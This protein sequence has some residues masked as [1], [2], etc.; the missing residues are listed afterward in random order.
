MT[1]ILTIVDEEN[2]EVGTAPL[3]EVYDKRLN[4][5]IV[6][7]LVFNS[8]G[9]L[10]LQRLSA[11]KKFCPG[12]WGTSAAGHVQQKESYEEAA[13][14]ELKEELC[15]KTPATMIHSCVYPHR[16]MKKFIQV[17]R[18][19]HDGP[20]RL[21]PDETM[22][23]RFFSVNE[24]REMVRKNDLVHPELAFVIQQLYP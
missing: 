22:E 5:R 9:E 21:D 24:A 7:V 6:H 2:K 10:F 11:K 4:H 19:V 13:Y 16:G 8:K 18:C 14:R 23:G 15:I 12:H 17:F 1:E 3:E 20:F